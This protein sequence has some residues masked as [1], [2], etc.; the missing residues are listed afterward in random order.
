MYLSPKELK[1][2]C[3]NHKYCIACHRTRNNVVVDKYHVCKDCRRGSDGMP[4]RLPAVTL[5][6]GK[7]YFVDRRLREL[8]NVNNPHD[9]IDFP[10]RHKVVSQRI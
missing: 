10:I 4:R 7:T 2:R 9:Y 6:N 5:S 3:K 8:R 1:A